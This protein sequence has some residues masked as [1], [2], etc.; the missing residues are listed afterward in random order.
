MK[1]VVTGA[2]GQLG[3]ALGPALMKHEIVGLGRDALD[4]TRPDRIAD[5]IAR[6]NGIVPIVFGIID[7]GAVYET[8]TIFFDEQGRVQYHAFR[9]DEARPEDD[10]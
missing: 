3:R 6:A 9:R 4:I 7:A 5:T 10:E 2:G 8:L 1:I